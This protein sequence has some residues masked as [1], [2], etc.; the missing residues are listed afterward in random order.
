MSAARPFENLDETIATADRIWWELEPND[1]LEA[2][3][4]HP[5]IGEKK[6]AAVAPKESLSWSE[7]E[8]SGT[9]DSTQQTMDELAEL[10]R[11]YE[12]KVWF[13]L[14]CLRDRKKR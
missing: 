13:H 10:N 1:W 4:S 5:R 14:H 2:F 8:Q 6:P 11:Q 3:H 12:E 9:R 7:S